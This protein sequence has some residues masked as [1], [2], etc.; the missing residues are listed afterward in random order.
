ME[1][2]RFCKR[3]SAAPHAQFATDVQNVLLDRVH[4]HNELTG[5]LTVSGTIQHQLQH[6]TFACCEWFHEQTG[7]V[8]MRMGTY[9]FRLSYQCQQFGNVVWGYPVPLGLTE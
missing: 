2:P 8:G 7:I 4:T 3:L 5:D 6:F 9:H 1:F